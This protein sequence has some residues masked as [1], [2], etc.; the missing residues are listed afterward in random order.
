[1]LVFVVIG[2]VLGVFADVSIGELASE[3]LYRI[4]AR[5]PIVLGS[6]TIFVL[7]VSTCAAFW[8]AW[9]ATG[10]GSHALR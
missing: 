4:S 8:P 3:L 5:D 2:E 10:G 7:V 6:V 9:S 1:V